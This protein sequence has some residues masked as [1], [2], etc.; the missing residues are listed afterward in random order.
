MAGSRKKMEAQVAGRRKKPSEGIDLPAAD[1]ETLPAVE[2]A[3]PARAEESWTESPAQVS[4]EVDTS[5]PAPP[6][7]VWTPV[8]DDP[9]PQDVPADNPAPL[10]AAEAPLT[11]DTLRDVP[12][13][14]FAAPPEPAPHQQTQPGPT[15]APRGNP[16]LP[17]MGGA[18]AAFFGFVLAQ[19]V[20]QGW[21]LDG[22]ALQIAQIESRLA[23]LDRKLA[24]TAA[25]VADPA[26]TDR[27]TALE[28]RLDGLPAAGADSAILDALRAEIAALRD[29]APPPAADLSAIEADLASLRAE[30]AA[31]PRESGVARELE[32]MRAA[33]EA[34]RAAAA[35]RAE[36]LRAES[37]TLQAQAEATA[38]AA[39]ARGAI[40]RVQAALEAGGA[41]D[42]AL[43]DLG[44]A[45]VAVPP[46]LATHADGLPQ[47]AELQAGFPDAARAALAAA[48]KPA[49]GAGLTDRLG[50]FLKGQTGLRST[51]P[52]D[53]D[54]PDAVLSRAEAALRGGDLPA[55]LA[56]L[57]KL[58]P[59]AA[60][61]LADWRALADTRAAAA[62]ALATLA[63]D[64]DAK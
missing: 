9:A 5:D 51:A 62:A 26:L 8:D 56:E 14:D 33:A 45:G 47:L 13:S 17:V 44:A 6:A 42:V 11:D 27:L 35:A 55:T 38:R 53:G 48:S 37:E 32:A 60:P 28:Q 21:P 50:A 24:E 52:R 46:E 36:A 29:A 63:A 22:N 3:E 19:A 12:V 41:F 23:A 31:I 16:L 25:P 64:L 57:D 43:A 1:R 18:V 58:P 15:P 2:L 54:D 61:A 7:D 4:L 10:V 59:E 20:P 39:L 34:E 49:E 30:L 40:L